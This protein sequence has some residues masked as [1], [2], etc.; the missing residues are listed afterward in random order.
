LSI[1]DGPANSNIAV[2]PDLRFSLVFRMRPFA[3]G[4]L[5]GTIWIVLSLTAYHH[6]FQVPDQSASSA[7][8]AA[9]LMPESA[10]ARRSNPSAT[11]TPETASRAAQATEAPEA[12]TTDGGRHGLR[13]TGVPVHANGLTIWE[14][15]VAW[16][17]HPDGIRARPGSTVLEL[18]QG[19]LEVLKALARRMHAD[20]SLGLLILSRYSQAEWAQW[21]SAAVERSSEGIQ[22][23][24]LAR[25]DALRGEL[26]RLGLMP[27]RCAVVSQL[28]DAG[29][30]A[31]QTPMDLLLLAK[32]EALSSWSRS[33]ESATEQATSTFSFVEHVRFPYGSSSLPK[34]RST[35]A[36]F[37]KLVEHLNQE[38]E[39]TVEVTGHTCDISSTAFNKKLGL[40]RAQALADWLVDQG[41]AKKRIAVRSAGES[42]P[43]ADNS[44][45]TGQAA[46]RRVDV[47]IR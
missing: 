29:F 33:R 27:D 36:P 8:A 17:S 38:P 34:D 39:L 19:A 24:G 45:E 16:R 28:D 3:I 25:G 47:R 42:E 22:D 15:G 18:E 10:D 2:D 14:Q 23:P 43:L 31:G 13:R 41:V 44:T 7:Y 5:L 37:Q 40:A 46:N 30:Q 35:L 21:S 32:R 26:L 12:G 20:S 11:T 9:A 4:S 1:L 6:L